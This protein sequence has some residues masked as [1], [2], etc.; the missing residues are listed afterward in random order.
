MN[1][2]FIA[3]IPPEPIA[4][5]IY[6]LK[7]YVR[8]TYQSKG[9]LNSPTHITLHMPFEFKDEERLVT[10]LDH[11]QVE[12]F[13]IELR[14][15]GCFEPRVIFI[16]VVKN[17]ALNSLQTRLMSFCKKELNVFNADYG[18]RAFHPHVTIAFRDLKKPG[19]YGAW[20]EFQ[21]RKYSANFQC[22][23]ISLL[24][25]DGRIWQEFS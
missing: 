11:F 5:D 23:K 25:H 15:F 6:K 21:S 3:V 9:A 7:E 17:E 20:K 22:H 19:F 24:K 8:D 12:P 18:D 1:K 2:Y 16:D 13:N 10:T 4:T 14:D